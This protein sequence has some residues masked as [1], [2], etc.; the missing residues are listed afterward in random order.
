MMN[1]NWLAVVN[2]SQY[3]Q[4]L[5]QYVAHL[6]LMFHV[7]FISIEKHKQKIKLVTLGY[8]VNEPI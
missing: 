6:K 1:V 3:I 4:M 7:N 5:N 8:F 2:V